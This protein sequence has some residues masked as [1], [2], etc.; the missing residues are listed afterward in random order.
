M[1][2]EDKIIKARVQ[3]ARHPTFAVC[4]GVA[5]WCSHTISEEEHPL[6]Y[7]NGKQ[8]VYS[9]KF[10]DKLSDKQV[11]LLV[12]HEVMHAMYQH[13]MMGRK[14]AAALDAR[15]LNLAM[16][17][18]INLALMDMDAG[19]GFIAM[20]EEGVPPTP[21]YRGWSV[22][23]IY[24][25]LMKQD[26]KSTA[27]SHDVH[28]FN[29][30]A[31]AAQDTAQQIAQIQ[32]AIREGKLLAQRI[33]QA[34]ASAGQGTSDH[35]IDLDGLTTC[36]IPWERVLADYM[37]ANCSG[38]TE[39]TW[40]R[41]NRRWM[42]HD[43]YMPTMHSTCMDDLVVVFDTSGSCFGSEAQTRFASSLT[44]MIESVKPARTHVLYVD[45]D[46]T[47]HQVFEDGAFDVA[48]MKPAGGGGTRMPAAFDWA[49]KNGIMPQCMIVFTDGETP[50]GAAPSYPVLWGIT[51]QDITAPF[52][53]TLFIN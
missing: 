40:R 1:K 8:C 9:R 46:V 44:T 38:K 35:G 18:F 27:K 48:T 47:A 29:T 37:T 25:E 6:A 30:S 16:D 2:A 20:P 31:D 28:D 51:S 53:Q 17:H 12:L 14:A 43:I 50:F 19:E 5:G 42:Q 41:P 23:R 36:P 32:D 21:A 11:R 26:S 49:T 7:T 24:N 3:I 52:G 15:T 34:R 39:S 4:S 10:V 22:L 45:T 13:H 33:K